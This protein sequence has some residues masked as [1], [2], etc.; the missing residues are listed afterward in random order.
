MILEIIYTDKSVLQI[1]PLIIF[2]SG[3]GKLIDNF[4]PLLIFK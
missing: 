2:L 1:I 4:K 3:N